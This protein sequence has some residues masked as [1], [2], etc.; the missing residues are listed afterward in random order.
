MKALL[1]MIVVTMMT[2]MVSCRKS[3]EVTVQS[4]MDKAN[5]MV[6]GGDQEGACTMIIQMAGDGRL[7]KQREELMGCFVDYYAAYVDSQCAGGRV[8][9]ILKQTEVHISKLPAGMALALAGR[10]ANSLIGNGAWKQAGEMPAFIEGFVPDSP[11]RQGLLCELR[12]RLLIHNGAVKEAETLYRQKLTGIPD[13]NAVRGLN[14]VAEA[15][16]DRG[17]ALCVEL[18]DT[19][20]GRRAI[21]EAAAKIWVKTAEARGNGE[22]IGKRL[23]ASRQKGVA[24]GVVMMLIDDTYGMLLTN[25]SAGMLEPVYAMCAQMGNASKEAGVRRRVAGYLLDMGFFLEKYAESLNVVESEALGG[26]HPH[27]EV[28]TCKIKAHLALKE[29]RTGE[30]VDYFRQFMMM[31]EKESVSREFDPLE[32]IWVTRE[33]ILGLNAKRIGDILKKTGRQEQSALAYKEARTYFEKAIKDFPDETSREHQKIRR[34]LTEIPSSLA[35]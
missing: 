1:A 24:D 3:P 8:E 11:E 17:D 23:V 25:P 27:A 26:N 6:Q 15:L 4:V 22:E 29:G 32:R 9:N 13:A 19:N 31:I 28:L 2:G 18:M 14:L 34:S 10:M 16:P 21:L 7:A 5:L 33:M 35:R 30:A 20:S 12:M